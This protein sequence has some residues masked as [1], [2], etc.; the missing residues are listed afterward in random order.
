METCAAASSIW[1]GKNQGFQFNEQG[2]QLR[3]SLLNKLLFRFCHLIDGIDC[4]ELPL[5]DGGSQGLEFRFIGK[6]HPARKITS[7][8]RMVDC[9]KV[10]GQQG[11]QG[12]QE[13]YLGFEGHIIYPLVMTNLANWQSTISNR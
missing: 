8:Q 4:L 7:T 13:L 3:L 9:L 2:W 5:P 6:K 12:Q 1:A 10:M 11:Q